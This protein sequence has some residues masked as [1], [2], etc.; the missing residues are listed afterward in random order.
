MDWD[1]PTIDFT[2][3]CAGLIT[4]LWKRTLHIFVQKEAL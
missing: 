3:R 4:D 2:D 1:D